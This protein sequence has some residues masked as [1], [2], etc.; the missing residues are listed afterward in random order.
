MQSGKHLM[1]SN[2]VHRM[3]HGGTQT[4][5]G[6]DSINFEPMAEIGHRK[7]IKGPQNLI[8]KR[9]TYGPGLLSIAERK[10]AV[11]DVLCGWQGDVACFCLISIM[12]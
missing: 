12:Y 10:T 3:T 9:D 1:S 7:H 2:K 4:Y 8:S 11:E 6:G 5:M